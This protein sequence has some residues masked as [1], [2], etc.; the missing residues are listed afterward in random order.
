MKV[1]A[2]YRSV[3]YAVTFALAALSA[4]A[5]GLGWVDAGAVDEG[6]E[7]GLK[8]LTLISTA[9]ALRNVTPDEE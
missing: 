6:V 1:P 2:K 3:L 5:T 4:V 7:A 8:M 9:L